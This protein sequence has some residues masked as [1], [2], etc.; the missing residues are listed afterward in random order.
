MTDHVHPAINRGSNDQ[1]MVEGIENS[2][3]ADVAGNDYTTEALRALAA[4][5]AHGRGRIEFMLRFGEALAKAKAH[6]KHGA[7]TRWCEDTLKRSPSWCSAHRRLFE[8]REDLQPALAWAA[9]TGHRWAQCFSVER[10]LTLISAWK[11]ATHG[12]SAPPP[13]ARRKASEIIAELRQQLADAK[14]DFVGLRD[15]LPPEVDARATELAA[16]A[17][18]NDVAAKEELAEIAR[19]FHWRYCDLVHR[20]TCGAPQG[21][22]STAED[23]RDQEKAIGADGTKLAS[24][25]PAML[26]PL[27]KRSDKPVLIEKVNRNSKLLV[28]AAQPRRRSD[29]I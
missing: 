12:D 22:K 14:A 13:T 6:L 24:T 26:Q 4:L 19:R 27:T 25:V 18:A 8:G 7:F 15:P 1:V 3:R 17:A 10:L 16:P 29:E 21:S 5:D 11:T 2:I 9:E 23:W 28:L 20:E